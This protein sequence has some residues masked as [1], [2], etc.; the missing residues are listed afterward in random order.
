M[1]LN[2]LSKIYGYFVDRRNNKYD[3]NKKDVIRCKI[4]VISI[5]NLSVG[6]SGKTPFTIYLANLL[7]KNGFRPGIIGRGYKR[8]S[9][10]EIVVS[11]GLF[12][13]DS[14]YYDKANILVSPEIAGDEM[15]LIA[16][17]TNCPV[18]SSESKSQA[19]LSIE[20]MFDI[21]CILVDDGFQHRRLYRD[22]D[23]IMV[24]DQTLSYPDLIPKGRLREKFDNLKRAD[25]LIV[26]A[27]E[28]INN[29][30]L[31]P[32]I[33][34]SVTFRVIRQEAGSFF[35]NDN[36]GFDESSIFDIVLLSSIANPLNYRNNMVSK[37][38]NVIKHFIYKD[39]Y[40]YTK[41]DVGRIIS[42]LK[43][44]K[45]KY[46]FTTEKD[47]VKLLKFS[48]IFTANNISL[49]VNK[50]GIDIY[51]A[52]KNDRSNDKGKITFENLVLTTLKENNENN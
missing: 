43:S 12:S 5:G 26:T 46:L 10:G 7:V 32:F 13:K 30:I 39:H 4:P 35:F 17:N 47:S 22:L 49:I 8:K 50:L 19:A 52:H 38:K 45:L 51:N 23:I 18:I 42:Y 36:N 9:K 15:Y 3:N 24:D 28:E 11:A 16:K 41:R 40:N 34:S 14:S 1:I 44:K 29:K 6:G 48:E 25:I 31:K 21:D 37:G 2:L 20:K 33:D 27:K